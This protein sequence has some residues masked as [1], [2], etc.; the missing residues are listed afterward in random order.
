MISATLEPVVIAKRETCFC[1]DGHSAV[2]EF[3][4][5]KGHD[6]AYL[7]DEQDVR[8]EWPAWLLNSLRDFQH[9]ADL[10]YASGIG[11][12]RFRAELAELKKRNAIYLGVG[13]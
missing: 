2:L 1:I 10:A 13:R 12:E 8:H 3:N 6:T 7:R 5:C 11:D 9:L 4:F